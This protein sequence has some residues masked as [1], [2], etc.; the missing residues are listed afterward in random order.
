MASLGEVCAI[1]IASNMLISIF[2][3]PIWWK[4]LT[5]ATGAGSVAVEAA[6]AGKLPGPSTLYR[7]GF[8]RLGLGLVRLLPRSVCNRI[9]RWGT[10]LYWL[11]ARGRREIVIENLMP[12]LNDREAAKKKSRELLRQFGLKLVDLFRYEAGL[13]LDDLFGES[14]GWERFQAA[15]AE[16]RGVLVLTVHL[17]DWEFGAPWLAR[18]G[19]ALQVVTLSEPGRGFT[20][21]RQDSR[22]RSNIDTLVIGDDPFAFVEI[23]RRLEAGATVALLVD[24]PPPATAV[25]VELFGKPFAASIAAAELARASGCVLL[26][27][28]LPRVGSK[29]DANV[30]EP[31]SY[32]RA[33]LRSR[34]ARRELTQKI[35]SAFEPVIRKHLDQWYHFVPVWKAPRKE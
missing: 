18:R 12:A 26:P 1:G 8:W 19:V 7:P 27:V 20:E 9:S 6:R 14:T 3:L 35:M 15:Q 31:I 13:P 23:I 17:G 16:K 2:L 33:G 24:R 4:T 25:T 5:G 30:L 32:E 34:E 21:L 22:A 11:L 10:D 28:Y 29:Y